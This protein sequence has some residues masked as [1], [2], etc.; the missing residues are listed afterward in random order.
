M[1]PHRFRRR[2]FWLKLSLLSAAFIS[3]V[4]GLQTATADDVNE[5][6]AFQ[7]IQAIGQ[8]AEK[9]VDA[10][11]GK[12]KPA[13]AAPRPAVVRRAVPNVNV[14]LKLGAGQLQRR[15]Q[16]LQAWGAA[17][18]EWIAEVAKLSDE[19]REQL[20]GIVADEIKDSPVGS[21]NRYLPDFFPLHM[22]SPRGAANSVDVTQDLKKLKPLELSSDQTEMLKTA[23]QERRRLLREG[24]VKRLLNIL[25]RELFL[26]AEQREALGKKIIAKKYFDLDEQCYALSPQDSYF[27]QLPVLDAVKSENNS[28]DPI[29]NEAQRLRVQVLVSAQGRGYYNDE[30]CLMF[31]SND[32]VDKWPS[33]LNEA[34]VAQKKRVKQACEVRAA[35][36]KAEFSLTDDNLAYLQLIGKGTTDDVV[37]DWKIQSRQRL[38]QYT[39]QRRM[40]AV[41]NNNFVIPLAVANLNEIEKQELWNAALQ[42]VA[43]D[44]DEIL[45]RRRKTRREEAA[46]FLV[47]VLDR[48]LWLNDKQRQEL[49]KTVLGLM[50]DPDTWAPTP[51]SYCDTIAMLV[52]VVYKFSKRDLASLADAQKEAVAEMKKDMPFD[53]RY[54]RIQRNNGGQVALPIVHDQQAAGL[55]FF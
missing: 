31:Q 5:K 39:K 34:L 27:K 3:P 18:R 7:F 44:S 36:C 15:Q 26:T 4:R 43:S 23:L 51:H 25:D 46:A 6:K 53:G 45:K 22:T 50:P 1:Q 35:F 37:S 47:S 28:T 14:A 16:R 32:G 2:S 20:D 55:G 12:K 24:S 52:Q 19:Q 29:L 49:H 40:V 33:K 11:A 30:R 17:M 13:P 9:A 42:Q 21:V 8:L 10:V 48:E 38:D 54:L 41:G